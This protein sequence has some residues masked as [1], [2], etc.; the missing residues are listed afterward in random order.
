MFVWQNK[1]FPDSQK[2]QQQQQQQRTRDL[3]QSVYLFI[4]PRIK[5]S[6]AVQQRL[7][8]RAGFLLAIPHK[9]ALWNRFGMLRTGGARRVWKRR[10]WLRLQRTQTKSKELLV[11]APANADPDRKMGCNTVHIDVLGFFVFFRCW[12]DVHIPQTS[13]QSDICGMCWKSMSKFMD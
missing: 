9:H 2:Q 11:T 8:R 10:A 4:F 1:M 13:V 7:I 5:K 3:L 12:L 6:W